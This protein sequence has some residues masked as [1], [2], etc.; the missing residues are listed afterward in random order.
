M[1]SHYS[2]KV[3]RMAVAVVAIIMNKGRVLL[4]KKITAGHFL[5]GK[6]H[7]PG[8]KKI[9]DETDEEAIK[10]EMLEEAG[11]TVTVDKL[12]DEFYEPKVGMTARWYVCSSGDEILNPGGDLAEAKWV[13]KKDAMGLCDKDA[14]ARWPEK[15]KLFFAAN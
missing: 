13:L 15:V 1:A 14:V 2:I 8:G 4:G 5:G 10:R 3:M 7:I 11:I 9:N 12:L 6:W